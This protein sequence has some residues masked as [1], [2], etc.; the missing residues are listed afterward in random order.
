MKGL[1]YS[2]LVGSVVGALGSGT[3][4]V[5]SFIIGRTGKM[6]PS[7]LMC[8]SG[9]IMTAVVILDLVPEA[10]RFS[11][12]NM[13]AVG[14]L[15]GALFVILLHY[16]LPQEDKA[17]STAVQRGKTRYT[18]I[19]RTGILIGTGIAIHNFPE[20]LAIGSGLNSGNAF[21]MGLALLLMLHDIPE[22]MAMSIPLL[23][24][25]V[26]RSACFFWA[27]IAGMPTA[28]GAF[29]G[30]LV[31]NIS[32]SFIGTCMAFAGGAMLYITIKELIPESFAIYKGSW[33]YAAL[34]LGAVAGSLMVYFI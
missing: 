1:L 24:G 19:L 7:L 4:A 31:G 12:I 15:L 30:F 27:V 8:F 9:G 2:A 21:G 16:L 29:F 26:K 23:M 5:I 13:T 20:G 18:P 34:V 22:G 6:L 3:G 33:A 14:M 28:L 25:G 11:G 10:Y 17:K 32:A